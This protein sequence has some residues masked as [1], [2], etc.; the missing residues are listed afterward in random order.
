MIKEPLRRIHVAAAQCQGQCS[1][2]IGA[3]GELL[4]LFS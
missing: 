2:H 4:A 1:N 3:W